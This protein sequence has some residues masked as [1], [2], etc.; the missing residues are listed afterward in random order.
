MAT[1]KIERIPRIQYKDMTISSSWTDTGLDFSKYALLAI[2]GSA[3]METYVTAIS[4]GTWRAHSSAGSN[5]CRVF[6]M[7]Y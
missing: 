1:S 2:R 5:N 3:N 6:Y 4:G 7:E